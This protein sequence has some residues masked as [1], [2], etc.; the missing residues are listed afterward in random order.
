MAIE[1]KEKKF[2]RLKYL[3]TKSTL[4]TKYLVERIKRQKEDEEKRRQRVIKRKVKKEQEQ[5]V[6]IPHWTW[7]ILSFGL[8]VQFISISASLVDWSIKN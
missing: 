7:N 5:K 4:Y 8:N 1:T 3:L 2:E 6:C